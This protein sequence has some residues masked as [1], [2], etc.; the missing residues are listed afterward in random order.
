MEPPKVNLQ[1]TPSLISCVSKPAI[2]CLIEN[3]MAG[4]A[5]IQAGAPAAV[6]RGMIFGE[7]GMPVGFQKLRKRRV[8]I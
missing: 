7:F 2:S 5:P 1:A 3:A 8:G 4:T 6:G